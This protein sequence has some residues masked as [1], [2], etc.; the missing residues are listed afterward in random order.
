MAER[1]CRDRLKG[2]LIGAL[3]ASHGRSLGRLLPDVHHSLGAVRLAIEAGILGNRG[4]LVIGG[5]VSRVGR[6]C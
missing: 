5:L 2:S 4:F 3:T 6:V 1:V